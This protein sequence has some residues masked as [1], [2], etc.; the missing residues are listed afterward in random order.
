MGY[1]VFDFEGRI[2]FHLRDSI[3][4][5]QSKNGML[6]DGHPTAALLARIGAS[7]P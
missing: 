1:T 6:P 3:R 2:D 4:D 7:P 5:V